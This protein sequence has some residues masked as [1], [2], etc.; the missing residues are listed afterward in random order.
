MSSVSD[1]TRSYL[2]QFRLDD[3]VRN[4]AYE[5]TNFK[6]QDACKTSFKNTEEKTIMKILNPSFNYR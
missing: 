6:I 5:M 4:L 3:S 2:E 1:N